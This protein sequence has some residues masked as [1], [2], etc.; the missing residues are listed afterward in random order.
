MDKKQEKLLNSIR[1]LVQQGYGRIKVARELNISPTTS[2]RLIA[3]LRSEEELPKAARDAGGISTEKKQAQKGMVEI[4]KTL[5]HEGKGCRKVAQELGI[6]EGSAGYWINRAKGEL[7]PSL[8]KVHSFMEPGDKDTYD[9][10]KR[11]KTSPV[12]ANNYIKKI[13]DTYSPVDD[14]VKKASKSGV[15]FSKLKEVLG[16]KNLNKARE[17]V[18]DNFPGCYISELKKGED[19]LLT[20][21][22][23]SSG[24]F[25]AIKINIEPKK[26]LFTYYVSP[27]K[28][29]MHVKFNDDLPGD[30][31][32]IWNLSDQHIGSKACRTDVLKK[33]I[34]A[35]GE[36]PMSFIQLGGD[37]IENSS[38]SS[39]GH[40]HDQ[41][42]T[43][44]EQIA[45]AVKM[46]SDVAY[47][48]V[49]I[50]DGNHESRGDR[51]ADID[52]TLIFGE[53]LKAPHF[54]LGVFIDYEWRG[55]TIRQYH[56]HRHGSAY[57]DSAIKK[58]CKKLLSQIASPIHFI[59]SGHTHE[60]WQSRIETS[61]IV[62]GRGLETVDTWIINAGSFTQ[63][64]GTY[65]EKYGKSPK[66]LTYFEFNSSGDYWPGSIQLKAL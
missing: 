25:E 64:T 37:E 28:N 60:A 2:G 34:A 8:D 33:C 48:I 16:V 54:K 32:K 47:K 24:E 14:W 40:P 62:T 58:E 6:S 57:D 36:D 27:W 30:S 1:K 19:V 3:K 12:S 42:L 10:A 20:P 5:V 23:D 21:I 39:A 9:I 17:I 63:D 22:P 43:P 29:Y 44:A 45:E 11:F 56:T 35:I 55:V 15:L 31:I 18:K 46:Y 4:V 52:I 38:R 59:S 50:V 65:S 51:F 66:D 61:T 49:D 7:S 13:N 41:Y 53:M 26:D